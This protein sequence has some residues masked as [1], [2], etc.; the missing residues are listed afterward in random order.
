MSP[1]GDLPHSYSPHV[2]HFIPVKKLLLECTKQQ[3]HYA[4]LYPRLIKLLVTHLPHLCLVTDWMEQEEK[5]NSSKLPYSTFFSVTLVLFLYTGF[6]SPPL[7]LK[8]SKNRL[9]PDLVK[10]GTI[11]FS[12]S[13]ISYLFYFML[14]Y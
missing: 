9:T 12:Y 1:Q 13:H 2:I 11:Y 3:V 7:V 8:I 4:P 14:Q 10:K 5:E 6:Q